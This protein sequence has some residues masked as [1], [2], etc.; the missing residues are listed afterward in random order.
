M[1]P[2]HGLL[3]KILNVIHTLTS[4]YAP[5]EYFNSVAAHLSSQNPLSF[6]SGAYPIIVI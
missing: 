3:S 2:T 4:I 6:S 5:V 1:I